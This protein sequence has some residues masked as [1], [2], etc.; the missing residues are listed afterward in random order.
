[1]DSSSRSD[2]LRF[3]QK[4]KQR[5]RLSVAQA[6][7]AKKIIQRSSELD[8]LKDSLVVVVDSFTNA[9]RY[10]HDDLEEVT[11]QTRSVLYTPR[12]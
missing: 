8:K 9:K 7:Q 11:E 5:Q 1:M 4:M 10:F 6:K 12:K 3:G 2:I